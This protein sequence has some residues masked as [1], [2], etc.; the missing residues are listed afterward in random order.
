MSHTLATPEAKKTL[1]TTALWRAGCP[2]G[3]FFGKLM[4]SDWIP[5]GGL[6]ELKDKGG[7]LL[8]GRI[9]PVWT[10]KP[11]KRVFQFRRIIFAWLVANSK[12]SSISEHTNQHPTHTPP[13]QS[14]RLDSPMETQTTLSIPLNNR[15][16]RQARAAKKPS[17]ALRREGWSLLR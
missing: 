1:P 15:N 16:E 13:P 11:S 12:V 9:D 4:P 5:E 7:L 8:D 3:P 17:M 14:N 2:D 6:E 10:I